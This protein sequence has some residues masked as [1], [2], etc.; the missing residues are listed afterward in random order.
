M[1]T[2]YNLMFPTLQPLCFVRRE[3][4]GFP[5]AEINLDKG[6]S[7]IKKLMRKFVPHEGKGNGVQKL[8]NE[9]N[10]SCGSRQ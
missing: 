5:L 7:T 2:R 3:S 6:R 8:H 1:R 9:G 10:H 4:W